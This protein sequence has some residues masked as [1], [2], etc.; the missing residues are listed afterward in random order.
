MPTHMITSHTPLSSR[1]GTK[2]P[3]MYGTMRIYK[4]VFAKQ[5]SFQMEPVVEP[6]EEVQ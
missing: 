2:L 1:N 6:N 4:L 3:A 5:H